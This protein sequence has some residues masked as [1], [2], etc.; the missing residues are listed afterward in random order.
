MFVSVNRFIYNIVFNFIGL[1]YSPKDE[2]CENEYDDNRKITISLIIGIT[3][4][5]MMPILLIYKIYWPASH[6]ESI[7]LLNSTDE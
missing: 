3:I 4:L 1:N 6:R 7:A 2:T 5:Y